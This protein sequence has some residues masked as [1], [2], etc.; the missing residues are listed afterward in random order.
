MKARACATVEADGTGATRFV[1]L[2]SAAPLLL[3]PTSH[4]LYLVGGAGGPLGGDELE[5]ELDVR[6][7]ACLTLRTSAASVLL[8]GA[9]PGAPSLLTIRARVGAG[10][11]LRWLPEPAVAAANCVHRVRT[12]LTLGSGSRLVW[13]EEVVLGREGEP[14]GSWRSEL[15]VD[16]GPRPLLRHALALGTGVPGWDGPAVVGR[17]KAVGSVLLVDPRWSDAPAALALDDAAVLP[18][19]GPGVLVTALADDALALRARLDAA[20]AYA[21]GA[22]PA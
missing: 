22:S 10:G 8:P 14:P 15:A 20:S 2:R 21:S 4:A 9:R 5:L 12:E 19:A 16:I 13:R 6:P 1:T 17:A 3:R 11:T 18:L 7:G